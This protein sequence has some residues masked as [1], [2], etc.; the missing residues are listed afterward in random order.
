[1]ADK[2]KEHMVVDGSDGQGVG[3]VDHVL[4]Q[5]IKLTKHDSTDGKHHLIPLS[6]VASV[7]G[8]KVRLNKTS[9]EAMKQ[10]RVADAAPG[11]GTVGT[12]TQA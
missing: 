10:W 2:V 11:A 6:W 8:D 1:M 5:D 3:K 12:K 9:D 7:E 4:G